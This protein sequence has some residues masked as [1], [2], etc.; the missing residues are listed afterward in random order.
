MITEDYVSFGTAKL[1]KEKGFDEKC[2]VNY[3]SN[4]S[5]Q[6]FNYQTPSDGVPCPTLQMALK[7][8]RE[9]H[10]LFIVIDRHYFVLDRISHIASGFKYSIEIKTIN[11][12][13]THNG[14]K[15]YEQAC[16][17]AIKYC[18]KNLI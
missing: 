18:L 3:S 17:V 9:V 6:H 15:S 13:Y 11:T 1:L 14:Y 2:Y 8:L 12:V 16:E 4:G 10:N 7:W 5:T